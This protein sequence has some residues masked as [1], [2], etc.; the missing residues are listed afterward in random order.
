MNGKHSKEDTVTRNPHGE[1]TNMSG[2]IT[3]VPERNTRKP[4]VPKHA[5]RD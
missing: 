5:K 2:T 4:N 3:D 1:V